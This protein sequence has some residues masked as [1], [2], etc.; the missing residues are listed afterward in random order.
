MIVGRRDLWV[1]LKPLTFDRHILIPVI[2]AYAFFLVRKLRF[3]GSKMSLCFVCSSSLLMVVLSEPGR[4]DRQLYVGPPDEA[5]RE[6]IFKIQLRNTPYSS[7]VNLGTLAA[8]TPAYTGADIS[9]VCRVASMAALEVTTL[10]LN[11]CSVR[12]IYFMCHLWK[13]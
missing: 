12:S 5:S 9:A 8:R 1:E 13:I 6:K 11:L 2:T 4:F 3:S 10:Y 7:L